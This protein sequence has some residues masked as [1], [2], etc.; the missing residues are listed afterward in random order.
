V[1]DKVENIYLPHAVDSKFFKPLPQEDIEKVKKEQNLDGKFVLFWNN[2]NARRK[3][4]GSF[5]ILV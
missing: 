3:L 4:S 2:R 5:N 1:T